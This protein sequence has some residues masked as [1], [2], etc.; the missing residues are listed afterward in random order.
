MIPAGEHGGDGLRLAAALGVTPDAVLDLSASMNPVAPDPAPIVV[1]HLDALARYPD[2]A[3]ATAC[4]GRGAGRAGRPGA[5]HQW[6]RRGHRPGR[7]RAG[8]G[9]G[10]RARLLALPTPPTRHRPRRAAAAIQSPQP[11]RPAGASRRDRPRNGTSL[12]RPLATG[13]WSRGDADRGRGGRG[14]AHQGARLPGAARRIRPR[15]GRGAGRPPSLPKQPRWAVNGSACQALPDL[16]APVDLAGWAARIAKLRHELDALLRSAGYP[17][18]PS[19][20][21]WWLFGPPGCATSW[22]APPSWCGTAPASACPVW[23]ASP[24]PTTRGWPGWRRRCD[25]RALWPAARTAT[26]AVASRRALDPHTTGGRTARAACP[27]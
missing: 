3:R 24:S 26:P 7:G 22:P 12:P 27:S 21:N 23:S 16:L 18:E 14:I 17:P 1:R 8:A 15:R 9:L 25:R 5:A 2:P 10:R 13:S 4:A 19:D 20:A 6:A 11:D